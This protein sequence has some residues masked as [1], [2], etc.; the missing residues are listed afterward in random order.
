MVL[1]RWILGEEKIAWEVVFLDGS[2]THPTQRRAGAGKLSAASLSRLRKRTAYQQPR[3][4]GWNSHPLSR[5]RKWTAY[6]LATGGIPDRLGPR[7]A[8]ARRRVGSAPSGSGPW[9]QPGRGVIQA[10]LTGAATPARQAV[11]V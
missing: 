10:M 6:Q 3:C 1:D 9:C 4:Q 5:S 8:P 2:T 11:W 7:A